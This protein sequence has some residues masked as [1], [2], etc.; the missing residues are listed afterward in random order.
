M[1]LTA[2]KMLDTSARQA[3]I[4]IDKE[5][6][7]NLVDNPAR[8]K[9]AR[10]GFL[11]LLPLFC[12]SSSISCFFGTPSHLLSNL[13][14]PILVLI[15]VNIRVIS[16][17]SPCSSIFTTLGPLLLLLLLPLGFSRAYPS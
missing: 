15:L 1:F 14:H 12:F 17:C 9:L 7:Q 10:R 2:E 4:Q 6:Q 5:N 11:F 13:D 8:V 3:E 16:L